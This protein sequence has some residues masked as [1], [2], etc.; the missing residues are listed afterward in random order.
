MPKERQFERT[1]NPQ[2]GW[3]NASK[4]VL[5]DAVTGRLLKKLQPQGRMEEATRSVLVRT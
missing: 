5:K 3:T 2:D 4:S 1:E